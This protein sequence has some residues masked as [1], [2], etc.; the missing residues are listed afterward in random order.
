MRRSTSIARSLTRQTIFTCPMLRYAAVSL[1]SPL[2]KPPQYRYRQFLDCIQ[3]WRHLKALKRSGRGHDPAGAAA[4]T[5]GQCAVECPTCPHPGRNLPE[6]WSTA[7]NKWMHQLRITVDANFKLKNKARGIK[8]D[9]PLGDGWGHW[10]P[11]SPYQ[12][13]LMQ[14][15][16]QAEVSDCDFTLN[17]R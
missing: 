9:P 8:N 7:K 12:E 3:I 1:H 4:T 14:Y 13:Y 17:I 6:N 2:T 11:E 10:V 15:G 16:H 5:A